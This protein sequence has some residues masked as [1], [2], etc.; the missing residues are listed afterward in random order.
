M[1]N[2]KNSKNTNKIRKLLEKETKLKLETNEPYLK[3][4]KNIRL[5]RS[6]LIK[7]IK[8]LN[9]KKLIHVYGASTK[10][11]TI[12]Q[13]CNLN[14]KLI[15]FAADRNIEKNGL[16]TLGSNISIISEEK[17]R[18]MYPDY[19]LALPWHFKKEFL[20]REK[21]FIKNGGKFIFLCL[22]LK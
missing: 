2:S 11:N 17:S 10:G 13:Y 14:S 21:K 5:I 19:Y 7:L 1:R 16:K 18:K 4:K 3:F 8:A 9:K 6:N 15:K 12:L 20:K 22:K